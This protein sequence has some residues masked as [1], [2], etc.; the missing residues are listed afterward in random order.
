MD[1]DLL[2]TIVQYKALLKS[3]PVCSRSPVPQCPSDAEVHILFQQVLLY[4]H[5]LI[6]LSPILEPPLSSR[7]LSIIIELLLFVS[8]IGL[9]VAVHHD[10]PRILL[11]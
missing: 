8:M 6:T 1:H 5:L 2:N 3:K 11:K 10:R 4:L 7:L 9:R